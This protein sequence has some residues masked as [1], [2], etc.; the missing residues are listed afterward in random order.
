MT[1]TLRPATKADADWLFA[2]RRTTMREYVEDMFG[3]W[4][5]NAQRLRFG[6]PQELANIQV[7]VCDGEDAGLLHVERDRANIFLANIQILPVFQ[8]R[9]LGTAVIRSILAEAEASGRPVRLQVLRINQ[10]ARRLYER[11]G[12][13]VLNETDSHTRMIWRPA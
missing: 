5:D 7:I 9:S 3:V 12:F 10:A 8:G 13:A 4:D 2:V 6:D 11:L 1:F